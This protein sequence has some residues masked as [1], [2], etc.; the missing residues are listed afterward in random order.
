QN[1]SD[2]DLDAD[3]EYIDLVGSVVTSKVFEIDGENPEAMDRMP[4]VHV[5]L[6]ANE[7]DEDDE[8]L[9]LEGYVV[10]DLV[11]PCLDLGALQ[12]DN[13]WDAAYEFTTHNVAVPATGANNPALATYANN[14]LN[15]FKLDGT[16]LDLPYDGYS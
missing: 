10:I 2:V 14:I 15:A 1:A 8:C 16:V 12:I 7:G 9:I 4:I 6:Y 3:N 11:A 5:R 13:Y